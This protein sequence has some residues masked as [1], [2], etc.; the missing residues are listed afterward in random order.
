MTLSSQSGPVPGAVVIVSLPQGLKWADGSTAPKSI[1]T[2]NDGRALLT[3]SAAIAGTGRSGTYTLTAS[4]TGAPN[5]VAPLAVEG[6]TSAI[7]FSNNATTA[8]PADS[9]GTVK[10]PVSLAVAGAFVWA[11]NADGKL[12]AHTGAADGPWDQVVAPGSATKVTA[13]QGT[14]YGLAIIGGDVYRLNGASTTPD[15]MPGLPG[16]PQDI[17]ASANYAYALMPDGTWW[18]RPVLGSTAWVQLTGGAGTYTSINVNE[19]GGYGWAIGSDGEVYWTAPGSG[20]GATAQPSDPTNVLSQAV[21]TAIG[22][23][24][25][26]ARDTNG[27]VY[28]HF[29]ASSSTP[30]VSMTGL[31]AAATAIYT[32]TGGN[33]VWAV[34]NGA[35]Y[36]SGNATSFAPADSA[37]A[38]AAAGGI[39]DVA[40][41]ANYAYVKT[42]DGRWWAKAGAGDGGWHTISGV[43]GDEITAL[44][45][46]WGDYSWVIAPAVQTC[47]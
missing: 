5:A 43:P 25:A 4:S 1:V 24:Y 42:T 23:S 46:N 18:W 8:S 27:A 13:S 26:Y 34:S 6:S 47:P 11:T 17:A 45:T 7:W 3:G 16:T 30:W 40:I 19:G 33:W 36:Y 35:L 37:G 31:P 22:A 39:A 41:G 10:N 29:G 2:G 12:Y 14:N 20:F 21:Q 28:S 44:S 38:L 15:P 9:S 32:N